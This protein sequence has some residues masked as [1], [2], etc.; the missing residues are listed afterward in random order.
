MCSLG[1]ALT[2]AVAKF[3]YGLRF[4]GNALSVLGGYGLSCLGLFSL[5]F[6]LASIL[7][8]ARTAQAVAMALF[9]PM[10]FLSGAAMPREIL[11]VTVRQVAR[12]LPLTHAVDLLRGLWLGEPWNRHLTEIAVLAGLF[13][14]CVAISLK[15]FRW[16]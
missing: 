6:L 1:L 11:P 15:T 2:I 7:P 12:F 10:M 13:L 3:V 8:N 14:F 16:E 9:Y 4:T 5:G